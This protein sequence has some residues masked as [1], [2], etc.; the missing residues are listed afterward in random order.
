VRT[1]QIYTHQTTM[2]YSILNG[3]L[4]N[5][6]D[7]SDTRRDN[8]WLLYARAKYDDSGYCL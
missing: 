8:Q 3:E 6:R 7:V 4:R 5:E 2:R 1:Y